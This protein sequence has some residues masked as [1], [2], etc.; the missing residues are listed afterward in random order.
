MDT[1]IVPQDKKSKKP[2]AYHALAA[3]K[4]FQWLGPYTGKVTEPTM[5]QCSKG[6]CFTMAYSVLAKPVNKCPQCNRYQPEDYH[7][8]ANRMGYIW[9][10]PIVRNTQTKTSW[11]CPEGHRWKVSYGA[12]S[13]CPEC[14][15]KKRGDANRYD[16]EQYHK[17]AKD[18]GLEWVGPEVNNVS[19][20]T[21]WRCSNGHEWQ[22]TYRSVHASKMCPACYLLQRS[23]ARRIKPEQYHEMAKQNGLEWLGPEVQGVMHKTWWKCSNGHKWLTPYSTVKKGASCP[24]CIGLVNGRRVSKLQRMLCDMVGGILNYKIDRC[25]VDVA[26]FV[27]NVKIAIEYDCYYWHAKTQE[28]D[29]RRAEYMIRR[30]WKA[31]TV[32]SNTQLP[33]IAKMQEAIR[34]LLDGEQYHEIVLD[35]W[36]KIEKTNELRYI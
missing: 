6:H 28:N 21:T 30:G 4:G 13:G 22:A 19:T 7:A 3:S 31:L 17:T 33:T 9:L 16:T 1:P 24:E 25:T 15:N 11:Q 2:E 10:G 23:E 12:L 20:L 26:L 29:K 36:G 32:K 34:I 8:L 5:W 14:R 27:G 35:D 18:R